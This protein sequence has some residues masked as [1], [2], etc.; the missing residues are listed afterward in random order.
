MPKII[1]SSIRNKLFSVVGTAMLLVVGVALGGFWMLYNAL[2]EIESLAEQELANERE[3]LVMVADFKKQVQEWKNVLL[4]GYD[5]K[6]LD[7]YWN[8]FE[9]QE[10]K[11]QE[12]GKVLRARLHS[13]ESRQLV[14]QF[15]DAHAEAGPAYRKGL[16]AYKDNGF[17][18]KAGDKAVSGIDRAPTK[19]LEQASEMIITEA[20]V[21]LR[22]NLNNANH[23]ISIMVVVML[24]AIAVALLLLYVMINRQIVVP[25]KNAAADLE[26]LASGD[27]GSRLRSAAGD[28]ELGRVAASA[29]RIQE[30]LGN[31]IRQVIHAVEGLSA[32]AR[33]MDGV[34]SQAVAGGDRQQSESAQ[35]ATAMNEMTSTAAEI[36]RNAADTAA[37]TEQANEQANTGKLVITEMM[38]VVDMLADD[39]QSSAKA[40]Q[41][42]EQGSTAI[43]SVLDVIKQIAE[44]TNL[45]ALNAAIEAAR[46]GEQGRGFAVVAD[47]VRTL[48]QR[49]QQS[50][51]EIHD[52]I[53]KLQNSTAQTSG[54]LAQSQQRAQQAVDYTEKA[55][56]AMAEI[57]GLIDAVTGMNHQVASAAEEQNAVAEEINRNINN[58]NDIGMQAGEGMASLARGSG[59][60]SALSAELQSAVSGFKVNP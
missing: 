55:V 48:A 37:I 43:G 24:A 54:V 23:L 31:I 59:E 44:Q 33:E 13:E 30:Q 45:L 40:M 11:L 49:T 20:K 56:E 47:E 60:L 21:A 50:T 12:A 14:D 26:I 53:E 8:K 46:A 16:Q 41:T 58:I 25:A 35:A 39:V 18:P 19:L 17:D 32:N 29:L 3:I 42:L 7:K 34:V 6:K 51:T 5:A 1:S 28:D 27:F 52:M 2:I 36:A 38:G 10:A 9:A 4:R 22:E 57:A 15:L